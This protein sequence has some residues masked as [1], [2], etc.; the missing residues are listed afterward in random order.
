MNLRQLK[1]F[2]ALA[3]TGNF[4][5][6]AE[7]MH[8]AQPPLSVSI[9]KLEEELGAP[10]FL[11]TPTGVQ[12]TAEGRAMLEDARRT[13]HHAQQCRQAVAATLHGE[14]GTLRIGIIGSATY[15]LLPRL[16]P[17]FRQCYPKVDLEFSESTTSKILQDVEAHHLDLGLVRMPVLESQSCL[18]TTLEEDEFIAA[19]PA[20]S[21]LAQLP[22]IALAQLADEPFIMYD[23]S[24]SPNLFAV[25]MM[26]CQQCGFTPR[27][28]QQAMQVQTILSLVESGLGVAIVPSVARRYISRGVRFLSLSDTLQSLK[29]GIAL[30]RSPNHQNRL[31]ETFFRHAQSACGL[32]HVARDTD[33]AGAIAIAASP[34]TP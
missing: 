10:L 14:G 16:V 22:R 4:H 13:I 30:A 3:E 24:K 18:L 21:P 23:K 20:S 25:A 19:V 12:L 15:N 2:V 31:V 5:K 28:T 8:M 1:Q 26:R 33:A 29:L 17:T 34:L 27:I 32:E 6:A 9:R 11:R 7:R